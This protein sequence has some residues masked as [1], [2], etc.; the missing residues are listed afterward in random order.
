[1]DV[2][3]YIYSAVSSDSSAQALRRYSGQV[4]TAPIGST[5]LNGGFESLHTF[6][7]LVEQTTARSIVSVYVEGNDVSLTLSTGGDIRFVLSDIDQSLADTMG[8]VMTSSKFDT[9]KALNYADFR[10][11]PRVVVKYRD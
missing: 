3:G 4:A 9:T 11:I 1:M 2:G 5:Y 10:F 8:S 6:V 7:Q